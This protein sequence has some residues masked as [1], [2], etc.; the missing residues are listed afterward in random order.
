MKSSSRRIDTPFVFIVLL[1]CAV[2]Y[3]IPQLSDYGVVENDS[4]QSFSVARNILEGDGFTTDILYYPRQTQ[5]LTVPAVQTTFPPGHPI[6]IAGL[7]R[8]LNFS[9]RESATFLCCLS[10]CLVAP[11]IFLIARLASCSNALSILICICWLSMSQCWIS[12]ALRT[13]DIVFVAF[14]AISAGCLLRGEALAWDWQCYRRDSGWCGLAGIFAMLAFLERYAGI[15]FIAAAGLVLTIEFIRRQNL[16]AFVR[17]MAFSTLPC[18]LVTTLFYRNYQAVGSIMGGNDQ[19]IGQPVIGILRSFYQ[20]ASALFGVSH[21]L[22]RQGDIATILFL[23]AMGL[24][25]C[26]V[27]MTPR[28]I[29]LDFNRVISKRKRAIVLSV[30]YICT[31]L[32]ALFYLE[33]SSSV[34]RARLLVAVLPFALILL[35][36]FSQLLKPQHSAKQLVGRCALLAFAAAT[37]LGQYS[38]AKTEYLRLPQNIAAVENDIHA[39]KILKGVHAGLTVQELLSLD[40]FEDRIL[41]SNDAHTV[42]EVLTRPVVGLASSAYVRTSWP[43]NDV[44]KLVD[45]FE[46][47][48]LIDAPAQC[49]ESRLF[50]DLRNNQLPDWLEKLTDSK[51][52]NI[53]RVR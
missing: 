11:T 15:F 7:S 17:L 40:D 24:T 21:V 39:V 47:A 28:G 31:T 23:F 35:A 46:I 52:L 32:V 45:D 51:G 34:I 20:A 29:P 22:L 10:F 16:G 6:F 1:S 9:V 4:L 53:Y 36:R 3:A 48:F 12:V 38:V 14:T 26:W 8:F 50:D 19:G 18:L 44:R 49:E 2:T 25:I 42:S 43:E 13:T 5:Q 27:A 37:I 30:A 33:M 41:L